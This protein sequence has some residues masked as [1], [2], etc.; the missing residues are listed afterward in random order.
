MTDPIFSTRWVHVAEEDT[1]E[2]AVYRPDGT[3]IPLS[4]K[5]RDWMEL[6]QDGS[7]TLF[8]PGPDDRPVARS[9]SWADEDDRDAARDGADVT[10]VARSSARL[11]VKVRGQAR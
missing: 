4:R 2:G 5:P 9:A 6:H 1:A 7:A 11:V 8:V 3:N 10:I